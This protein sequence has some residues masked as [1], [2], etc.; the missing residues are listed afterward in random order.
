M[1]VINLH[2][3]KWEC[4]NHVA[5]RLGTGP[6]N[7]RKEIYVEVLQSGKKRKKVCLGGRNRLTDK[8]IDKLQHYFKQAIKM[9]GEDNGEDEG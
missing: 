7:L 6:R 2:I 1:E 8:V 3:L 9:G 5:K 4:I